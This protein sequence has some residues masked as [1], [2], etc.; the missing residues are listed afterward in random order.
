M[1]KFLY[2]YTGGPSAETAEA[3]EEAMRVWGAWFTA[4]GDMVVDIGSPLGSGTTV[5][6]AGAADGGASGLAG[7]SVVIAES[8]AEAAA[9]AAGCPV[10]ES[11]GSVEVYEAL[12]M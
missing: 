9:K 7:Y 4:L 8:L 11:G 10:V 6:S 3:Q 12:P 1:A 5:T 2:V